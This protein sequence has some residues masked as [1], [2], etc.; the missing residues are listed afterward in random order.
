MLKHVFF[1]LLFLPA[2]ANAA[3]ITDKLLAGMYAEP[4]N[5]EQPTQ[6]LPSGTPV[7]LIGEAK[8]F[9]KVQLV[10]GETGWVE[11]RFLSEE[12]RQRLG[13]FHFKVNTGSFKK[14]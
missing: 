5:S 12:S 11:K 1:L 6:L 4:N 7:E 9:V 8:G 10:G 13:C 3:H 2:M 14:S